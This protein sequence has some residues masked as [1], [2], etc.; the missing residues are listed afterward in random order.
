MAVSYVCD[1][2]AAHVGKKDVV[3]LG[4]RLKRDYCAACAPSVREL[5]A[6]IDTLHSEI[7]ELWKSNL[8]T[9]RSAWAADHGQG[10][11]PDVLYPEDT[12]E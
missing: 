10:R 1:G 4:F 12:P 3:Q 6:S 8:E 2:C 5:M 7:A 9:L 11:L